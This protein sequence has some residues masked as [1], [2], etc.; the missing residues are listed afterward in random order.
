MT[1]EY[2]RRPLDSRMVDMILTHVPSCDALLDLGCGSG[3]YGD[4]LK[5]KCRALIGFDYDTELCAHVRSRGLYTE[6]VEGD[7]RRV[8][9]LIRPVDVVFC[10]ETLEHVPNA[11]IRSVM[12]AVESVCTSRIVIT[13]PNP[14]SPHFETDPTHFLRYSIYS[15]LDLLNER[16]AFAYKLFPL[17]FSEQ[18]LRKPIFRALNI[19]AKR[20][21]LASPTVLY[22]GNSKAVQ[23]AQNSATR[24]A[25][26]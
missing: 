9:E 22:V 23:P 24:I 6:V 4:F 7:I 8:A 3:L 19:A 10:S 20:L 2:L 17:G 25:F 13:V 12:A 15:F 26:A 21:A 18:N 11:D 1:D 5:R 14:L 16:S